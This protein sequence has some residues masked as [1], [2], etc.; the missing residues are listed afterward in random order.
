[1]PIKALLKN[2]TKKN[3]HISGGLGLI[4][5]PIIL[6]KDGPLDYVKTEDTILK[7]IG[8]LHGVTWKKIDKSLI[9][10]N[11]RYIDHIKIEVVDTID[12]E[13]ITHIENYFF[14]IDYFFRRY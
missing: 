11:G 4:N 13:V 1:M 14:D 3:L 6:D 9:K 8:I 10:H 5:D 7:Y 2:I 12:E